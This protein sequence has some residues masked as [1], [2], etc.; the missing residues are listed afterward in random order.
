MRVKVRDERVLLIDDDPDIRKYIELAVLRPAGLH[1]V[2]TAEG[3]HDGLALAIELEPDLIVS[4]VMHREVDG[5]E[6]VRRLRQDH[7]LT[8]PCII[9]C[10]ARSE[11]EQIEEGFAAGADEY[12]TKPFEA[13]AFQAVLESALERTA[14]RRSGHA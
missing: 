11:P 8:A 2:T 13:S 3:G 5:V 1:N 6:M 10:T 14:G 12:V 4:D 7:G 9:L